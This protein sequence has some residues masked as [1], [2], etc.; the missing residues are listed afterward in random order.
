MRP[1]CGNCARWLIY[2]AGIKAFIDWRSENQRQ[3][4]RPQ[5][6]FFFPEDPLL[7]RW[8]ADPE[9]AVEQKDVYRGALA[10]LAL[11][12]DCI[13]K[14]ERRHWIQRRLSVTP[15][16]IPPEFLSLLHEEA[17]LGLATLAR[18]FSLLKFVDGSWWLNGTAK[19]RLLG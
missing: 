19:M 5:H 15:S 16:M 1:T 12:K 6:F 8:D 10:Y 14:G 9:L 7:T 11:P 17:P 13:S 3:S 4:L 18:F 2:S